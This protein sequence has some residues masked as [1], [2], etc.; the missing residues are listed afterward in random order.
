M[1]VTERVT[2]LYRLKRGLKFRLTAFS[3]SELETV[4]V[5]WKTRDGGRQMTLRR[6]SR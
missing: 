5:A 3:Y 6:W 4:T 1:A 2:T